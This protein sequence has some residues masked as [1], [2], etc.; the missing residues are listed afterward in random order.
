MSGKIDYR[1]VLADLVKKGVVDPARLSALAGDTAGGAPASPAAADADA[2]VTATLRSVAESAVQRLR[3]RAAAK[4]I[5]GKPVKIWGPHRPRGCKGVRYTLA[6][7]TVRKDTGLVYTKAEADELLRLLQ[8]ALTAPAAPTIGQALE[9]YRAHRVRLGI[10]PSTER[11]TFGR[12][13]AFFGD[14]MQL[15]VD[16]LSPVRAGEL[17]HALQARAGRPGAA[18]SPATHRGALSEARTFYAWCVRGGLCPQNPLRDVQPE[19]RLP[20]GKEQLRVAEARRLLEVAYGLA[21]KGDAGALAVLLCL[22]CALRAGEVLRLQARDIDAGDVVVER[23]KTAN[24]ARRMEMSPKLR[25]LLERWRAGRPPEQLLFPHAANWVNRQTSRLCVLAGVR[26]VV[27]H[28][29]RGL[30]S[31]AA[32][33]SG[34]T[35]RVVAE[36][37][38]HGSPS[39]TLGSY[40]APGS[41]EAGAQRLLERR[42]DDET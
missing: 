34:V 7:G 17:Y 20:R 41:A 29:L 14:V 10:K 37:L 5:D 24:A 38:G 18:P 2:D 9:R 40:A 33:K 6:M 42:L 22:L 13:E 27:A 21:E 36:A 11:T 3:E 15:A 16:R 28:S 4:R 32:L 26:R 25:D 1:E 8:A 23:G 12:L 19:G 30:H 39:T 31:T 35:A